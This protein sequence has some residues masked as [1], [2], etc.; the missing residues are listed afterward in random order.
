MQAWKYTMREPIFKWRFVHFSLDLHMHSTETLL[1]VPFL[2]CIRTKYALK[3]PLMM[4]MVIQQHSLQ[5]YAYMYHSPA[6]TIWIEKVRE[7]A[8][9]EAKNNGLDS[10][11]KSLW[12]RNESAWIVL[13]SCESNCAG[14]EARL[15]NFS[16]LSNNI[17][18]RY[19]NNTSLLIYFWLN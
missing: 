17:C 1:V 5:Y 14:W 8:N 16:T 13:E 3:Y 19:T 9:Q 15:M 18:L 7:F 4:M 2:F 11:K 10:Y 12:Y 6:S